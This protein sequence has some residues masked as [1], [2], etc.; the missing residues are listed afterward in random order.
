MSESPELRELKKIS[1]IL[2]FSNAPIIEKEI[3]KIAN[4]DSRKKMWVLMSGKLLQK[5]I[6]KAVGVTKAAVS[7]FVTACVAAELIDCERGEAPTRKLDYVPPSW[8]NL[9]IK[10]ENILPEQKSTTSEANSTAENR[11]KEIA[12]V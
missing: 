9:A 2:L 8:I 7:Y 11:L 10:E 12:K 5:D 6:A 3:A 4:S 1:K